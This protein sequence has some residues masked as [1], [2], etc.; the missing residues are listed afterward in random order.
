VVGGTGTVTCTAANLAKA[1]SFSVVL[2]VNDTAASG[3]TITNTARGTSTT[4]DPKTTNNNVSVK[5]SVN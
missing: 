1:A 2:T 3:S 4:P 5:T